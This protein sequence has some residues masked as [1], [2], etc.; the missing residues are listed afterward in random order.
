ME[1]FVGGI[2]FRNIRNIWLQNFEIRNN[3]FC[4]TVE[5][6]VNF[7]ISNIFVNQQGERDVNQNGIHVLNLL[8]VVI[9]QIFSGKLMMIWLPLMP[10]IMMEFMERS[11]IL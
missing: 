3:D 2:N 6:V 10:M 11:I 1:H 4:I 7:T 5:D 8:Q 9:F